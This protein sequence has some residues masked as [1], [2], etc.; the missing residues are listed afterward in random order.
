MAPVAGFK[1]THTTTLCGGPLSI[2][3]HK[4]QC[5]QNGGEGGIRTLGHLTAPAV[6]KTAALSHSA[7]SP[8]NG[9]D[10]WI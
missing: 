9:P 10:G 7:T 3:L 2:G 5:F 6:F 1:P 8:Y 4:A